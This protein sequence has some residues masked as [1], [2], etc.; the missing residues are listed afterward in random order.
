MPVDAS[1]LRKLGLRNDATENMCT[2]SLRVE[3]SKL[4]QTIEAL[5]TYLGSTMAQ[6][7]DLEKKV[8]KLE[9]QK[10]GGE[11]PK[12]LPE[13][14]A[15]IEAAVESHNAGLSEVQ[16][17]VNTHATLHA[18]AETTLTALQSKYERRQH[19]HPTLIL[20]RGP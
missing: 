5:V 2:V 18:Q 6:V 17:T 15:R 1:A 16:E 13:K 14:L 8:G 3:N 10:Q 19:L 12:D 4:Q 20:L 11:L 9:R 7:N